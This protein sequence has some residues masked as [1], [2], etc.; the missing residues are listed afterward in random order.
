MVDYRYLRIKEVIHFTGLSRASIYRA[1]DDG[2]FPLS[3]NLTAK[4]VGW[5]DVEIYAWMNSRRPSQ[6]INRKCDALLNG[7]FQ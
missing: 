3:V 4:S 1:M 7:V 2:S 6:G 5:K